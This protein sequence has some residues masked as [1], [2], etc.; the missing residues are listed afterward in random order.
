MK[1]SSD[2]LTAIYKIFVLP[3]FTGFEASWKLRFGKIQG[4]LQY[5]ISTNIFSD[6]VHPVE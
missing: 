5:F 2:T 1:N 4:S 3:F 6:Y